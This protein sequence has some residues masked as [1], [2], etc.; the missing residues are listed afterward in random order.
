MRVLVCGDRHWTDRQRIGVRLATLDPD[1]DVV[2]HGGCRGADKLAGMAAKA[3]GI[4]VECYPAEWERYGRGAGPVRN[5]QMLD[6]GVDLL[7]AFHPDIVTSKGTRDMVR[8]AG[9]A[10][11]TVE[12]INE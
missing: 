9:K 6:R 1:K 7:I 11:V 5:Q 2:I 4:P 12:V 8:R 3:H 10:G